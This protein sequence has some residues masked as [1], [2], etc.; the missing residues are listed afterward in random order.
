MPFIIVFNPALLLIG[1]PGEVALAVVTAIVG[2]FGLSAGIEGYLFS[3]M[4]WLQR[5]AFFAGGLLMTIPG[6]VTDLIGTG[7]L[8]LAIFWQRMDARRTNAT[9][10]ELP[11]SKPGSET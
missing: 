10:V 6:L 8:A 11:T 2:I 4:N 9:A 1:S 3:R 5:L 7:V